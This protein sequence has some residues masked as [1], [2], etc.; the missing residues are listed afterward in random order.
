MSGIRSRRK[1][2]RFEPLVVIWLEDFLSL[3]R[4]LERPS[5]GLGADQTRRPQA[6]L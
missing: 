3:E 1:G 2:Y 5:E 6:P 4:R